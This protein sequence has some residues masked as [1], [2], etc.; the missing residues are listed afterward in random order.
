MEISTADRAGTG[1][2]RCTADWNGGGIAYTLPFPDQETA[3][4]WTRRRALLH[5]GAEIA[6]VPRAEWLS[7]RPAPFLQHGRALVQTVWTAA[8]FAGA[9][10]CV[11]PWLD[12][13]PSTR[14]APAQESAA[15]RFEHQAAR[16]CR[17]AAGDN[18]GWIPAG[19]DGAIVCTDKHGRRHRSSVITIMERVEP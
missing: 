16:A 5:P 15:D 12:A 19:K 2:Y 1:L 18:A 11:G 13:N 6:A 8:L 9:L 14:P 17:D 3:L 7:R 4:E 10:A